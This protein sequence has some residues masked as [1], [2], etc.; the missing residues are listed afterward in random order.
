MNS[1]RVEM[2]EI[3]AHDDFVTTG[4]GW[5]EA[6]KVWDNVSIRTRRTLDGT[7][8]LTVA[9]EDLGGLDQAGVSTVTALDHFQVEQQMPWFNDDELYIVAV[10]A[11]GMRV[12][13]HISS[14]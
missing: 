14:S 8:Q 6:A 11:R 1:W 10:D 7:V 5:F 9:K 3:D 2:F 13:L 4:E 12:R